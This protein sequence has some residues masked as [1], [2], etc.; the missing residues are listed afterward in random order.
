M[1]T[2][3]LTEEQKD[4]QALAKEFADK[5]IRPLSAEYDIKGET[6]I[7]LYQKA[8]AMGFTAMAWPIELG[9]LGLPYLT[10]AIVNEELSKGDVGFA[11]ALGAS[12]FAARPVLNMG[13]EQQKC[14]VADIVLNGGLASF[15]L[16]EPNA[17]SDASALRTTAVK[18]GD[19]YILNGRK[20][21]IT[22]AP[23][24]QFFVV[25]AKTDPEK[26]HRGIS[27]FLVERSRPGVS[28][29]K[30]EDKMGFRVSTAADVMLEDVHVPAENLIGVENKGYGLAM[31]ILDY[32]R[33]G[34]AAE[35]VGLAQEA[36][37]IA[38]AYAKER[39]TFGKPIGHHQFI[40]Y[41]LAEME[42]KIQAAR[43]VTYQAAELADN[44]VAGFGKLSSCA[45]L[46]ASD[47]A[48]FVVNEAV[49]ILGGYGYMKDY[50]TEKLYRDAKLLP[51]FEG[52]NEIQ[53]MIIAGYLLK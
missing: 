10:Q 50:R 8:A 26:G 41:K 39:V 13:N 16:T 31:K 1:G 20:C 47:T 52:T 48:V 43:A 49:Q 32:S 42:S 28:V 27:A 34:V 18:S 6:P 36:L 19:E 12:S 38:V 53:R 30:H 45:K 40:Q 4:L 35:A 33:I 37:D 21:F 51:I 11:N 25:F 3:I 9:G 7:D 24:A 17:G 44:G 46:L 15:A 22:N 2:F 5:E 29:G 23:Y 14:Y